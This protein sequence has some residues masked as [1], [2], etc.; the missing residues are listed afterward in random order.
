M[1]LEKVQ[2]C[3]LTLVKVTLQLGYSRRVDPYVT[4]SMVNLPKTIAPA[5]Q[6]QG[7]SEAFLVATVTCVENSS[8]EFGQANP[9]V[10][11]LGGGQWTPRLEC[12]CVMTAFTQTLTA[13]HAWVSKPVSQFLKP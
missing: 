8:P 7:Q 12:V 6:L 5:Q 13:L 10:N 3:T 2:Q 4:Q 9:E 11:C 1:W